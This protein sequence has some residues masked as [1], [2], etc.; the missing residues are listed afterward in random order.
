[1]GVYYLDKDERKGRELDI[2][3]YR[4]FSTTTDTRY[5][6][7]HI[8][9]AVEVKASKEPVIFFSS[10]S[11]S[12]EGGKGYSLLHW[13]NNLDRHCL[14]YQDIEQF[15]PLSK[16]NRLARNFATAKGSSSNILAGSLSAV[17]AAVSYQEQCNEKYDENSRDICF[18][19]PILVID[20]PI[21]ECFMEPGSNK[22]GAE[23][24]QELVLM[25][26]YISDAY[27][28]LSCRV[29]VCTM[30]ALAGVLLSYAEW[31]ER[32]IDVMS[33]ET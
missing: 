19:V 26:H 14:S 28:S 29:H 16:T 10:P 22:L 31:G 24:V 8:D 4:I 23:E 6:S 9:F 13:K 18:F 3:A 33:E 5:L 12:Y 32:L 30:A 20:G 1:M 25:Q 17:K 21:F 7:C 27:G 11:S 2:Y 15:R